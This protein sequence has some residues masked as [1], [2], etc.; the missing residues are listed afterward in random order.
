MLKGDAYNTKFR[1]P[2]CIVQ[3]AFSLAREGLTFGGGLGVEMI[4]DAV[5]NQI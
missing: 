3:S 5:D 4:A 2:N 1:F